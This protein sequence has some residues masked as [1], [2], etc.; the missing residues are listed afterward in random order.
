MLLFVNCRI[1]MEDI[2]LIAKKARKALEIFAESHDSVHED[3]HKSNDLQSMCAVGSVFLSKLFEKHGHDVQIYELS[4]RC[5][6]HCFIRVNELAV[7]LT[8][9]QFKNV[10]RKVVI[11]DFRHYISWF[12]CQ[13]NWMIYSM[14]EFN[15]KDWPKAQYPRKE[16]LEKL[17]QIYEEL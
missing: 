15:G 6:G 10:K 16:I 5:G 3:Y 2:R 13:T 1:N 12:M 9:T 11:K 14:I 7:D 8:A 17:Q 4:F